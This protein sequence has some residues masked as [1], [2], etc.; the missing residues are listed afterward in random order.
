M[1]PWTTAYQAPLSMGFSRQEYTG[2]A[3]TA[4]ISTM[5]SMNRHFTHTVLNFPTIPWGGRYTY[6]HEEGNWSCYVFRVM[7]Q[8]KAKDPTP[9]SMGCLF[10]ID[11]G[12]KEFSPK[13]KKK[14]YPRRN[15]CF[16]YERH[17]NFPFGNLYFYPQRRTDM[18]T[19]LA[20]KEV[21][22]TPASQHFLWAFTFPW[23]SFILTPVATTKLSPHL[24]G[25]GRQIG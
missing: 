19:V 20:G 9:T 24:L 12:H 16:E 18:E 13:K 3:N 8:Y 17:K 2:V 15:Q 23:S 6:H 21:G 7:P 22:T 1:T 4:Y 10:S 14:I 5:Y 25:L 11:S